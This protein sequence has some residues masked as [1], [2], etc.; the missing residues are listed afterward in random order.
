[1]ESSGRPILC[2]CA[3]IHRAD[4]LTLL[5]ALV[6]WEMIWEGCAIRVKTVIL[7]FFN[8][9]DQFCYLASP[10]AWQQTR[11]HRNVLQF[12]DCGENV[13]LEPCT[14]T[15]MH[16]AVNN[17]KFHQTWQLIRDR[18][19]KKMLEIENGLNLLSHQIWLALSIYCYNV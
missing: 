6:T 18:C 9:F 13:R 16:P 1:M 17:P 14:I 15:L 2:V 3:S 8:V 7:F 5:S 10:S 4:L 12:W 19:K 11:T